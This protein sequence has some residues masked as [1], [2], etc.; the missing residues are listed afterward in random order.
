MDDFKNVELRSRW[1]FGEAS[2]CRRGLM[3]GMGYSEAELQRPLIGVVNS[4]NE[5]NPGH[6]HLDKLAERVKQGI[7]EAGGLP[8][9]VMTTAICDGMVLKDPKYIEIPS[10][11][12]IADQVEITVEGNFFD[13][14]VMLSTCDSIVPGHLMAAARLDIPTIV[15]TG[16]YMPL[17]QHR[18]KEV[19]HIHAQDKVGTAKEGKIDMGE[20]NEL[21]S[22][23]WGICGACSSMTT[24]NSMCMIAEALGLTLPGNSS[25]SAVSPRLYLLAYQAGKQIL[26]LVKKGIT[27]RKIVTVDAVKNAIKLDMAVA[28]SSNL[29]LHIPA[30][31]HEA[32]YDLPWWKYFDEASNEVPLMSHLAPGGPYS[33]KDFDLAGGMSAM[34]KE[35]LPVLNGKCLTVTGKTIEENVRNAPN[36]NSE[37]IRPI[38]NP[39]MKK[40]GIGVLYGSLAPEGAIIKIAAVPDQLM[41]FTGKARV[42]EALQ[43]SLDALRR[44]EIKPGD[45]V[46]LRFMGLKG[47]F[48]TTAFTLQEELKG[49]PELFYSCAVITDGRFS[50]GTSGLSV[51]YLSP[52]AA[53][54]GPL[55][56][57]R[58]G[59]DIHIDIAKRKI[60]LLISEDEVKVRTEEFK[61]E[62]EGGEYKRYL[63]LF[64]KN[65]SSM[66]KG[67]IWEV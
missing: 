51:G 61:W 52:E 20:Y 37:V 9:E 36:Y 35:L 5:Y 7:R 42:Y 27:A 63:N 59:D 41:T 21:I 3:L 48:G 6:V 64:A 55:A 40:P 18:G 50:G 17:G 32:G 28:G 65:V 60:D 34:L 23:S 8:L 24:A 1:E 26:E 15:V 54:G 22:D 53:L 4:W 58:N 29:I 33:L 67:G 14:M 38:S 30:I 49:I 47:R 66:A 16:G 31:A 43:D 62:F 2:E 12:S 46:V 56:I 19:V 45:A 10:R 13:G 57:V 44:G 39:V 11:N 25:M